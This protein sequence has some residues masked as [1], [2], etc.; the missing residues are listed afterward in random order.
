MAERLDEVGA[1]IPIGRLIS[2]R[3]KA[4]RRLE[5]RIPEEHQIA[6]IEWEREVLGGGVYLMGLRL[7]R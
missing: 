4:I 7:N 6:L 5:Q 1:A 3:L 2:V